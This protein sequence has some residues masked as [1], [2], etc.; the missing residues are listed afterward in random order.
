M[1]CYGHGI[2][3]KLKHIFILAVFYLNSFSQESEKQFINLQMHFNDRTLIVLQL[4]YFSS[5]SFWWYKS[6]LDRAQHV[7]I[8]YLANFHNYGYSQSVFIEHRRKLCS[9]SLAQL[10]VLFVPGWQTMG[11]IDAKISFQTIGCPFA[12]PLVYRDAWCKM[13]AVLGYS[14]LLWQS[15]VIMMIEKVLAPNRCQGIINHNADWLVTKWHESYNIHIAL[16]QLTH[17]SLE[18]P[19]GDTYL[20]WHWLR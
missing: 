11:Y 10:V 16:Q 6:T 8:S 14:W 19:Y 4:N 1:L 2:T 7:Q 13:A 17:C 15:C 12:R 3:E 18:M 9:N 20:G 5:R